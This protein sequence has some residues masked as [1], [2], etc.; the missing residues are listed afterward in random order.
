M[1]IYK[2]EPV[3]HKLPTGWNDLDAVKY[4]VLNRIKGIQH[5]DNPIVSDQESTYNCKNMFQD[6]SGNLTVRPA[7]R[8][9]K[10][11]TEDIGVKV[12]G[13]YN[14]TIG[15]IT[16]FEREGEY[17]I[18]SNDI[19]EQIGPGNVTIQE[20]DSKVYILYTDT[21]DKLAF[22]GW[23]DG[24]VDIEPILPVNNPTAPVARRFN[25]LTDKTKYEAAPVNLDDPSKWRNFTTKVAT[26]IKFVVGNVAYG[27]EYTNQSVR[28]FE[29]TR[30]GTTWNTETFDF[31][32]VDSDWEIDA[33]KTKF[34]VDDD[35]VKI[36]LL[37]RTF[38]DASYE[39]I[40][41]KHCVISMKSRAVTSEIL[42]LPFSL[43]DDVMFAHSDVQLTRSGICS[44]YTKNR[45]VYV[46]Y[47]TPVGAT[48]VFSLADASIEN[49]YVSLSGVLVEYYQTLKYYRYIVDFANP[50][51]TKEITEYMP[52]LDL[53]K[54][55]RA[56]QDYWYCIG[57]EVQSVYIT[58][59]GKVINWE[60]P[61]SSGTILIRGKNVLLS[62]FYD[63]NF[64]T[65]ITDFKQVRSYIADGPVYTVDGSIVS[66]SNA[67]MY[68]E[69]LPNY[70]EAVREISDSFPVLSK[71]ED[72]VLTSFYLDNI[73]WFVTKHRVFGTGVADEEFTIKYFDPMKYFH[74]DEE[75]TGAI[76]IS[77][78][79]FWVFHTSGAYLIYK[80]TSSIYDDATGEYVE[81]ITWLCTSTAKSK[82]C[83]FENAVITLPVT[84][85]VSC[86]TS[87]DISIVQMYENVQTDERIL[88]PMT[89]NFQKFISDL[90]STTESVVIGVYKYATIYFLNQASSEGIVPAM[91]YDSATQS[92]WYWEFPLKQ[93]VQTNTTESGMNIIA[94]LPEGQTIE[95][96]LFEEY[97]SYQ[98]GGLTYD[99]Y[100]DR[101][102]DQNPTQITWFWESALL[103]FGS[104]DYRK[105][106]LKTS[107]TMSDVNNMTVQFDYNFEVYSDS[108]SERTW[109]AVDKVVERIRTFSYKNIIASFAYLQ[110]YMKNTDAKEYE[111]TAYTKPKFSTISF[112]YRIL[113]GGN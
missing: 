102:F 100:A 48:E 74:F 56:T 42:S 30:Y 88:S 35:G 86:V 44:L 25:L 79:S 27:I 85:Y 75:I 33:N 82:G 96:D 99:I 108:C 36:Y 19:S 24:F 9:R 94:K 72:K 23:D 73:Y 7:L 43:D 78:T 81:V 40:R 64:N 20:S 61:D 69:P 26:D 10:V 4:T 32:V 52:Q 62:E 51:V 58:I 90:L 38:F 105:Q 37:A 80:S 14:T 6:A 8:Y 17:Y 106:L 47:I 1:P 18:Q 70:V 92:W 31:G 49:I 22:K 55:I 110:L 93:V 13:V 113:S 95:Y 21:S 71:I 54:S 2:R 67:I 63:G 15:E 89:L 12:L 98:I 97:Y 83:D 87:S 3:R 77:D 34:D 111:F 66:L 53:F 60:L 50:Y 45:T 11:I 76:R 41:Y 91:V 5:I 112:K 68:R 39:K 84:N 59:D 65:T 29:Y 28:V 109:T 107:F 57:D 104:V 16:H 103:H 46:T 101:L